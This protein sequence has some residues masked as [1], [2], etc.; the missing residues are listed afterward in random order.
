MSK[1]KF[2]NIEVDIEIPENFTI[3]RIG[4]PDI[5]DKFIPFDKQKNVYKFESRCN[6]YDDCVVMIVEEK[7]LLGNVKEGQRFRF[8][9]GTEEFT[10]VYMTYTCENDKG[11]Y[12]IDKSF[13]VIS[14]D[15]NDYVILLD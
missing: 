7:M 3:V 5:G 15:S 10:K 12:F 4:R 8:I 14:I 6:D 1:Q 9:G 2:F 11:Y 13:N